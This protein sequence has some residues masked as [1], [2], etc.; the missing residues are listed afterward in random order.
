[1][2]ACMCIVIFT[3]TTESKECNINGWYFR[4][5]DVCAARN[6]CTWMYD[7]NVKN[8]ELVCG[9]FFLINWLSISGS[10]NTGT[11]RVPVFFVA[12]QNEVCLFGSSFYLR[13]CQIRKYIAMANAV[14]GSIPRKMPG[15]D[16][17]TA[18]FLS[19]ASDAFIVRVRKQRGRKREWSAVSFVDIFHERFPSP[20]IASHLKT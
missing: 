6:W 18:T 12:R 16:K 8:Y 3:L 19:R 20:S 15:C 9:F 11:H 7:C 14:R 5:R 13:H 10:K 2:R 4:T 1:M 17:R